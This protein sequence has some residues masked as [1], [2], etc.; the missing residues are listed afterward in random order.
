[1][2]GAG[3]SVLRRGMIVHVF[4]ACQEGVDFPYRGCDAVGSGAG[5]FGNFGGDR[6]AT[7]TPNASHRGFCPRNSG[8]TMTQGALRAPEWPYVGKE[9]ALANSQP[10]HEGA[11]A[12]T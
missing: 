4:L 8:K 3:E 12:C 1:M 7:P 9:A 10:V 6:V 11:S 5:C 2:L